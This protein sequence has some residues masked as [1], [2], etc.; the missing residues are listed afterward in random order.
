MWQIRRMC[1]LLTLAGAI[2]ACGG[3]TGAPASSAGRWPTEAWLVS[4][5]AAEGM[6]PA[7]L[8]ELDAAIE[9]RRIGIHS[10]LI[11]RNG[12]IVSE[13]YVPPYGAATRHRQYSV[14]KSVTSALVGAAIADGR[15]PGV[16]APL[17][18]LLPP[19]SLAGDDVRRQA[20]TLEHVLTMTTGLAWVEGDPAYGRMVRSPDWVESVLELP[21]A[22]AP[23]AR[24]NYCSGCSH[25]LSAILDRAVERDVL[26]YAQES[27]FAPLGI[28]DLR[29]ETDPAGRPVGGWGLELTP[30]DMAKLGYLYL[31]QGQWDGRQIIPAEWVEAS[32]TAHV[33]TDE[34]FGY[35]YQWWTYPRYGAY[36]ARGLGGQLVIVVPERALVVV[37][38]ADLPDDAPLWELFEQYIVPAAP[39]VNS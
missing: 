8:S 37:I 36:F 6:D 5:P 22:E 4:T 10:L 33:A 13:R 28:R 19:G 23:G 12:A 16:T 2:A 9:Q 14:T 1:L 24:F 29:W 38:T 3:S 25:L 30:R 35:G 21:M 15:I 27:L 11:V 20:I 34:E 7:L 26:G 17:A 18:T 31:N 39:P 32:V